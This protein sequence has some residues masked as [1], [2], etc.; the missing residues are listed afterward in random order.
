[1]HD[2]DPMSDVGFDPTIDGVQPCE[3]AADAPSDGDGVPP[4]PNRPTAI[5]AADGKPP[6]RLACLPGWIARAK[7]YADSRRVNLTEEADYYRLKMACQ[8]HADG[9]YDDD[10]TPTTTTIEDITRWIEQA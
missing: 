2:T 8:K 9:V 3:Y 7:D 10:M 6:L 1:M 4:L 5:E